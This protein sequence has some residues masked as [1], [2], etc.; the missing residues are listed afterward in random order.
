MQL[1]ETQGDRGKLSWESL[2]DASDALNTV[3]TENTKDMGQ[4]FSF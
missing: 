1:Q 4:I 2:L 3:S